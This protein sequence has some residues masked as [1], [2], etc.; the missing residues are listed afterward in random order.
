MKVKTAIGFD[1]AEAASGDPLGE[2]HFLQLLKSLSLVEHPRAGNCLQLM[3]YMTLP[4]DIHVTL[5]QQSNPG[6]PPYLDYSGFL[7]STCQLNPFYLVCKE[8]LS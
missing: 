6:Y 3:L 8:D 5:S 4:W 2:V 7:F 1:G